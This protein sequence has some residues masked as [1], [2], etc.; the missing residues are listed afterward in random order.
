MSPRSFFV[1]LWPFLLGK[2]SS[3]ELTGENAYFS[4]LQQQA[5][6]LP[7]PKKLWGKR[8]FPEDYLHG[9]EVDLDHDG[10]KEYIIRQKKGDSG[11]YEYHIYRFTDGEWDD[12][13]WFDG[14]D[15]LLIKREGWL[16]DIIA[17][18]SGEVRTLVQ[19]N[20]QRYSRVRRVEE[21]EGEVKVTELFPAPE[22]PPPGEASDG[23]VSPIVGTWASVFGHIG[24]RYM[25]SVTINED[26]T[27]HRV[28][29]YLIQSEEAQSEESGYEVVGAKL[30]R[31]ETGKIDL[32][33]GM[34]ILPP[35]KRSLSL[36]SI[37]WRVEK[38]QLCWSKYMG[39]MGG[40]G[41]AYSRIE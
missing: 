25:V 32:R 7:E 16:D 12:I 41:V 27:Y 24:P 29:V 19:F 6:P 18:E 10:G 31:H 23:W 13:G 3:G 35:G 22:I 20:G 9:Y 36:R 4:S 5:G 1:L 15:F 39:D 21:K 40:E 37:H 34:E 8:E 11:N 28:S 33:T 38:G 30:E 14:R 17:L 26:G 2:V